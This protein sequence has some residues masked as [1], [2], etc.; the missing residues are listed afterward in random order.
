[1]FKSIIGR[2][3]YHKIIIIDKFGANGQILLSDYNLIQ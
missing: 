1:M 3:H 2:G